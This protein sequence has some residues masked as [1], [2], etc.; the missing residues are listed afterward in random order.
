[1]AHPRQLIRYAIRAALLAADTAAED[2]IYK[3]RVL[4]LR[5][6]QLPAIS[7]Y[8]LEESVAGDSAQTAPRELTRTAPV[9]IEAWIANQAGIDLDDAMDDLALEIETAMH[10]DP[11][12]GDTAGDSILA[13]TVLEVIEQGDRKLGLV[14]LT[15]DVTYRTLAP[16]A[17]SLDELDDFL[18][19]QATH[20][21]GGDVHEDDQAIDLF[22]VQEVESEEVGGMGFGLSSFGLG[23]FG[24]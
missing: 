5:R 7:I 14:S 15:Y 18:S 6:T 22:A 1:M 23:S 11:Y 16:E 13:D 19:M 8:T 3:T 21:L 9:V 10:A 4:P 17:P 20:N 24:S 2:R 12:L